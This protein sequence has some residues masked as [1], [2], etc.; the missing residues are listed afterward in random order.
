MISQED[1]QESLRE[2]L[3]GRPSSEEGMKYARGILDQYR[4]G[5]ADQFDSM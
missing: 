1:L 4:V 3:G 5:S 2:V